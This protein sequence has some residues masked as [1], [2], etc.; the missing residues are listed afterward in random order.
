ML[1]RGA[2]FLRQLPLRPIQALHAP[3][4]DHPRHEQITKW[5]PFASR[6]SGDIESGMAITRW[7]N[8]RPE[9]GC[10]DRMARQNTYS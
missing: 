6:D 3:R 4:P 7:R 1:F 10:H 2:P 8:I 5:A 9:I